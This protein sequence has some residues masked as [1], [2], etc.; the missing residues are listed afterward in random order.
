MILGS[1]AFL[2]RSKM[3]FLASGYQEMIHANSGGLLIAFLFIILSLMAM[4]EVMRH[5]LNAGGNKIRP[6]AT[7]ALTFISNSWSSTFPGGAAIS[8]VY[9]FR[10]TRAWGVSVVISSWFIVLS[11]ALSTVWLI[12][13]GLVSI[14]FLGASFSL[15]PLLGSAAVFISLAALV[16]WATNNP[17]PTS[18]I[19]SAV[20]AVISRVLR[21]DLSAYTRTMNEHFSQLDSVHLSAPRFSFIALLSLGNWLF[22]IIAVWICIW[23]VTGVLPSF[24]QVPNNTTIMGVVLAFVTAKIVGTAQLSP[25]GLGPVEAAMTASLVAVGMTASS[26]FGVVFVYRILSFAVITAIGWIIY[27]ISV[28]RGGI[29]ARER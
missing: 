23:A 29:R 3:P 11:G 19:L 22:E 26:A 20:M 13:L 5:L 10:N 4:S 6:H 15:A 9:Q 14:V 16:W 17:E 8:T 21:I 1:A 27:F 28:A 25:A 24:E 18:R 12:A 2:L 7:M